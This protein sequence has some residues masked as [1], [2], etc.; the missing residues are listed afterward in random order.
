MYKDVVGHARNVGHIRMRNL[1]REASSNNKV[2]RNCTDRHASQAASMSDYLLE[3]T[4]LMAEFLKEGLPKG[5][6]DDDAFTE[7]ARRVS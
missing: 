4:I 1:R 2:H 5:G 3:D 7:L 6:Q